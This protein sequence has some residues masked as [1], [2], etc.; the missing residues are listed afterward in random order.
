MHY[1]GRTV[2]TGDRRSALEAGRSILMNNGYTV[3]PIEH[4]SFTATG[5]GLGSTQQNPL[6]G[7]TEFMVKAGGGEIVVRAELGGVRSMMW[8]LLLFPP[9]LGACLAISF[10]IS[11]GWDRAYAAFLPIL[12]WLV[13]SPLMIFWLRRRTERALETLLQ[14]MATVGAERI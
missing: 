10:G 8:F 9:G 13:I 1:E 7:A 2:F 14:N 4:D 12:P 3:S 5:R 11:M 6:T